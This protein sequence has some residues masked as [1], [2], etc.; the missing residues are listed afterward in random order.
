ML[1]LGAAVLVAVFTIAAWLKPYDADGVPLR[2]ASHTQLGMSPC[3]FVVLFNRPC[4]TCG[5]TTSF[6]LLMHGDILASMRA[7]SSGTLLAVGLLVFAPWCLIAGIRGRWPLRRWVEW[8]IIWGLITTIGL[9]IIRW[10][11]VVGVP[12]MCGWA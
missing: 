10:I 9:A 2:M 11:I 3:N 1:L 4:P 12:W 6:A 5:M 7:N 8:Y